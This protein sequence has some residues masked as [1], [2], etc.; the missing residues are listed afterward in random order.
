M[1][2]SCVGW[3]DAKALSRTTDRRRPLCPALFFLL[4]LLAFAQALRDRGSSSDQR[5]F[6]G[7]TLR[8]IGVILRYDIEHGFPGELA[9]MLGQ[10]A[11]HVGKLFVVHR[12]S[13]L[14]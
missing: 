4:P 2:G 5:G 12:P 8:Q 11:V 1:A 6:I 10:E 9:M 3:V 13:C 7:E 14:C